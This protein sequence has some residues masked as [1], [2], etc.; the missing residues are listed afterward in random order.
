[1]KKAALLTA[2][3]F[4]VF[5]AF[6]ADF[7]G[8]SLY[9]E[10]TAD[11]EDHLDFFMTAFRAEAY[12]MDLIVTDYKEEAGFTFRFHVKSLTDDYEEPTGMHL[13]S[14]YLFDNET[15]MEM[16]SFGWNFTELEEMHEHNSFIFFMVAAIIPG[17]VPEEVPL[18]VIQVPERDE[19]WRNQLLS[20]RVSID[21]PI[22]FYTLQPTGLF[23]GVGAYEG[24]HSS[25]NR[26]QHLDHIIMPRPG[27]TVGVEWMFHRHL[28]LE[29]NFQGHMGDPETY[30]F[31]NMAAGAQLKGVFRPGN[32]M[33]QPYAAIS[34]PLNVSPEFSEFPRLA[35]GGGTQVSVR[36][37]GTG[38]FFLDVNI[39]FSL[40][41]VFRYNPYGDWVPNPPTLHYRRFVV[42]LGLGYRFGILPR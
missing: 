29:L 30:M 33:L 17:V 36:G 32:F 35:V 7:S 18:I 22:V 20:I 19:R 37:I 25:P 27:M 24:S 39:M 5:S 31:F 9:I 14:I 13:I 41:D 3:L 21:Y 6:A 15:D 12:A 23:R 40:G 28:S 26:V 11:Q 8:A 1:M 38:A 2:F 16:L 4:A 10:G 42:G 34:V